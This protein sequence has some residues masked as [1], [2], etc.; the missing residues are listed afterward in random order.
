MIR[1][2]VLDKLEGLSTKEILAQGWDLNFVVER[3]KIAMSPRSEDQ[4]AVMRE[5]IP[6]AGY[7]AIVRGDTGRVFQVATTDYQVLQNEQ[8]VDFMREFAAAGGGTFQQVGTFKAG[9]VIY[10]MV[11]LKAGAVDIKGGARLESYAMIATSHDGS[12]A[13]RVKPTSVYVVCWNT[14]MMA[15][16]Q[17]VARQFSLR[18]TSKWTPQKAAEARMVLDLAAERVQEAN[19]GSVKL[20]KVTGF[21]QK[22]QVEYVSRLLN[23]ESLLQQAVANSEAKLDHAALLDRIVAVEDA[24]AEKDPLGRIGRQILQAIVDSPGANMPASKDT[25]WGAFNGVTYFAD[26]VRGRSEDTRGFASQFGEGDRLKA[27]AFG[28]ALKMATEGA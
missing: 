21:D 25:L 18:H 20:A 19:E 12:I 27:Q 1:P 24:K 7:R 14:F 26:H 8:I 5:G 13:T 3:R 15:L 17:K 23:G 16:A 28:L 4:L 22:A 9:A 2:S 6:V 10:A 11:K